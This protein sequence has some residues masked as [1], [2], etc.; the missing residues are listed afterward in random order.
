MSIHSELMDAIAFEPLDEVTTRMVKEYLAQRYPEAAW[1]VSITDEHGL[2]VK[3][4]FKNAEEQTFY[5]LKWGYIHG[6]HSTV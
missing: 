5:M 2:Y 3:A 6:T 4:N 1:E